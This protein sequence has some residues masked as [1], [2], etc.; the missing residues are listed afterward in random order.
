MRLQ[1]ANP[2]SIDP[3]SEIRYQMR[4]ILRENSQDSAP[5]ICQLDD[6]LASRPQLQTLAVFSALPGE[7]NL[8]ELSSRHPQRRWVYPRVLGDDLIF[9]LVKHPATELV[10]G[11]F[12]IREPSLALPEIALTEIDVFFCPGLAFDRQGGRLGRGRGF[13]DR[14]LAGATH[15]TLKIGVC[16]PFQQVE[17][18]YAEPHDV[19]M[20][21]VFCGEIQSITI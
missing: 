7:V 20:D 9:H 19:P 14:A 12:D 6:W 11:A 16:F 21:A 2:E 10:V 5:V 8:T 17:N 18:T 1:V 15:G 3:K 4:R 13:Y